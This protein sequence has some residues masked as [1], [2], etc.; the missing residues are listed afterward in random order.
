MSDPFIGE[1]R[2]FAGTFAPKNARQS[3]APSGYDFSLGPSFPICS[4]VPVGLGTGGPEFLGQ[5]DF[6]LFLATPHWV[7]ILVSQPRIEPTPPP[8]DARNLNHWT[9][10]D[11]PRQT[12]FLNILIFLTRSGL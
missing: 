3:E 6:F 7:G 4:L 10:R 8:V 9:A 1:I 2:M 12:D 11:V 5:T